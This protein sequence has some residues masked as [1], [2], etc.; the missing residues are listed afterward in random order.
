[1][2][3][4]L[5]DFVLGIVGR[6]LFR[7][8]IVG[9]EN[10]P[11]KGPFMAMMN[12]IYFIDPALVGTFCPRSIIIMSKIEN[13]ANPLFAV[14]LRHYGS[15]PVRR[16]EVDMSA[17]RASLQVLE[18]GKGLLMAPEGTRSRTRSLQHAHDGAA[19][20]AVRSGV[21]IVPVALSGQENLG[22]N[23]RRLR[24]TPLRI[25]FG[26]PFVFRTEGRVS[27]EQLCQMS[28]EAMYRLAALLPPPYRG[29]YSDVEQATSELIVPYRGAQG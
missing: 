15:F 19:W 10:V 12:H 2:F 26:E 20:L 24:R 23:I 29:V 17:I 18:A 13:Y 21:P 25:V 3:R 11:A 5:A 22:K 7:L 28:A 27:R 16:G 4:R 1:M 14:V 9:R 8:E 6:I